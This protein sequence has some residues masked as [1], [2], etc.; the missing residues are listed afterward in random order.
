[1]KTRVKTISR[2]SL[3]L[4]SFNDKRL[5]SG[6]NDIIESV[7]ILKTDS[8]PYRVTNTRFFKPPKSGKK[9]NGHSLRRA[10]SEVK[11][12]VDLRQVRRGRKI[13]Q[14]PR[15]IPSTK[16][17][18]FGVR[19]LLSV[20]AGSPRKSTETPIK[21]TNSVVQNKRIAQPSRTV[22]DVNRNSNS[23]L[24]MVPGNSSS[25]LH[26]KAVQTTGINKI[27]HDDF[28]GSSKEEKVSDAV[29]SVT[30]EYRRPYTR[31]FLY[32]ENQVSPFSLSFFLSNEVKASSRS[33]S[34]A[35]ENKKR[36]YRVA[37]ANRGSIRMSWWL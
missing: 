10:V 13:F 5:P 9:T 24:R 17:Q 27:G 22:V 3:D 8:L 4:S 26:N 29:G 16:R 7:K 36:I 35:V 25:T 12:C 23:F 18:L 30:S 37:S 33:R 14:I 19:R 1:M 11:P 20:L 21:K 31:A 28:S 34:R 15:I 2:H 6:E 32:K